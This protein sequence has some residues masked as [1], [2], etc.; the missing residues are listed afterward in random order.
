MGNHQPIDKEGVVAF[1]VPKGIDSQDCG[2]SVIRKGWGK[3]R[4]SKIT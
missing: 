1:V 2:Q 3:L 4:D